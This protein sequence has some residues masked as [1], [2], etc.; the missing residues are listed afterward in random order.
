MEGALDRAE[1]IKAGVSLQN[2]DWVVKQTDGTVDKATGAKALGGPAGVVIRGNAD[3][4][5]GTATNK[6]TVIWGNHISK[7]KTATAFTVGQPLSVSAGAL[8]VG[9]F[10]TDPIVGYVLEVIAAGTSEDASIVAKFN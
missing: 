6:A 4:T 10:G 2:G 8:V 7:I 3:S 5:S 9:T 1:T